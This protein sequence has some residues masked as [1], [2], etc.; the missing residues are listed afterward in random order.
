M[1]AD[2]LAASRIGGQT[3]DPVHR[4]LMRRLARPRDKHALP[5]VSPRSHTPRIDAT[6]FP[7]KRPA[8]TAICTSAGSHHRVLHDGDS[9]RGS[10]GIEL[11]VV[12]LRMAQTRQGKD[13]SDSRAFCIAAMKRP[14]TKDPAVIV[15]RCMI[16]D[17]GSCRADGTVEVSW[18][19]RPEIIFF[20]YGP[21]FL[22]KLVES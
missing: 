15:V 20:G 11:Q 10:K 12:C 9:S 16:V 2:R 21:S 7:C 3:M 14:L 1:A 17:R 5:S 18:S 19:F 6:T 13:Q 4:D 22:L 8:H